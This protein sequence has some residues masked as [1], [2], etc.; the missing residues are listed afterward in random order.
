M[1]DFP[2]YDQSVNMFNDVNLIQKRKQELKVED[3][4]PEKKIINPK[5]ELHMDD[6]NP[7]KTKTKGQNIEDVEQELNFKFKDGQINPDNDYLSVDMRDPKCHF[8]FACVSLLSPEH[9]TQKSNIPRINV[10]GGAKNIDK[11]RSFSKKLNK[12][13]KSDKHNKRRVNIYT[14]P[15]NTW[16]PWYLDGK[17]P[18][19][20]DTLHDL[21]MLIGTLIY[22]KL[23]NNKEFLA[24]KNR[25]K[26]MD[27]NAIPEI[28]TEVPEESVREFEKYKEDV[29]KSDSEE[30]DG[31]DSE[32]EH[33]N[34]KDKY[35][36][37]A[38][39]L[40]ND[41]TIQDQQWMVIT[42]ASLDKFKVKGFKVR[43]IYSS[44]EDAKNRAQKL[45][46]MDGYF[47]N[48]PG[49]VG[50]WK[51]AFQD[52]DDAENQEYFEQGMQDLYMGHKQ[53]QQKS[54]ELKENVRIEKRIAKQKKLFGLED[55][56]D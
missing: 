20:E 30:S 44:K 49:E 39:S 52:P 23:K 16:I 8:K 48:F 32:T 47:H 45:Q 37:K 34:I 10:R 26:N 42:F 43:G 12:K 11:A 3:I 6:I 50:H 19:D 24:R 18:S 27:K 51:T 28:K 41:K 15:M 7:L 36:K 53:T 40:K 2:E 14:V 46:K 1:T 35:G 25:M 38:L 4:Q 33:K 54:K 5:D 55:D 29:Q 21:N 17:N 13:K 22:N 56:L 9:N 31:Y